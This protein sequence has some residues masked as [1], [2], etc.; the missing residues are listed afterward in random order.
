MMTA[1]M[2]SPPRAP[3]LRM[4]PGRWVT[5]AIGVPF[6]LALIAWSAFSLVAGIGR[7]SFAINTSIPLQGGH[8]VA[9]SGGG[10]ITVHQDQARSGIARLT[11]TVEYSLV[12]PRLTV[13]GDGFHLDCRLPTGNCGLSAILDVPRDTALQLTSEGGNMQVNGIDSNVTLD[14]GGGDVTVSGVGGI[15]DVTTGGGNLTASD[16]GSIRQFST[17]GGDVNGTDLSAPDVT[18]ES[19]GGNVTLAFTKAPV[20][21]NIISDGGD[22]TIVLP[23]GNTHYAITSSTDG[24]DYSASVPVS[25]SSGNKINVESGGG[26]VS[27]AES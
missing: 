15:A 18:T 11:G 20:N 26:N 16:L 4:T 1:P 17:D 5:L 10:D 14:S 23:Q 13:S 27:I 2:S 8:L 24:G 25:S 21:L 6:A 7:A 12:R 22:I 9:S 3:A 19:G